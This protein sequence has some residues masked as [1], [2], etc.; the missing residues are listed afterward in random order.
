MDNAASFE[1]LA[2][3]LE[4]LGVHFVA[5]DLPGHGLSD[6][7]PAAANYSGV[8]HTLPAL[9]ALRK[10]GW[11]REHGEGHPATLN[12]IG[13]SMG[14]GV[15]AL[16]AGTL[17][18]T[19][20]HSCVFIE[21]IGLYTHP[22]SLAPQDMMNAFLSR[23]RSGDK[24][25]RTKVY[26][27][28]DAAVAARC[29]TVRRFPGH[30]FLSVEAATPMVARGTRSAGPEGLGGV[31]F[32]HDPRLRETTAPYLTEDQ[33]EA[34]LHAIKCRSLLLLAEHGWPVPHDIARRRS[35]AIAAHADIETMK[36]AGHHLHLEPDTRDAVARRVEDFLRVEL[37]RAPVATA[38]AAAKL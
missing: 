25:G 35:D 11:L 29:E 17:G 31:A 1:H 34:F 24:P 38:G 16:L 36:G 2:P 15:A 20:V 8:S 30:Q 3:T 12:L 7:L 10:L 6:H 28:L 9:F 18:P 33:N 21:G 13:H 27:S 23:V 4:K 32:T 37:A 14:A 19:R 5:I 22:P 26:D